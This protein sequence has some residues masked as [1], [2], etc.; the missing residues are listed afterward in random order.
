[1]KEP[2]ETSKFSFN[3]GLEELIKQIEK[4]NGQLICIAGRQAMGKSAF[5]ISLTLN[6]VEKNIPVVIFSLEMPYPKILRRLISSYSGIE[7]EKI[8][9]N[10]ISKEEEKIL[11]N[12]KE[13]LFQ[14]PLYIDDTVGITIEEIITEIRKLK[15]DKDINVIFIDYLQLINISRQNKSRKEEITQILEELQQ[16]SH[17]I[18][19]TIIVLY[20]ICKIM[21]GEFTGIFFREND[22]WKS[23]TRDIIRSENCNPDYF[24]KII[25]IHRPMYYTRASHSR[26]WDDQ[27]IN[28]MIDDIQSGKQQEL[29][30]TFNRTILKID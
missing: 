11:T 29:R 6:L 26:G 27:E 15:N 3:E 30:L 24:D 17:E 5:M 1:M 9:T 8:R 20:Q 25:F 12:L 14:F 7:S 16:L 18:N 22:Y 13:T 28:V 21:Q 19:L 2:T 23:L 4:N 10:N